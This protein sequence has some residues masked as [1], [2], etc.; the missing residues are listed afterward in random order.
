MQVPTIHLNGTSRESLL[1]EYEA[2]F[3]AVHAAY[4]KVQAL[5]VHGRDYYVQGTTAFPLAQAE[6]QHRLEQLSTIMHELKG[7][8]FALIKQQER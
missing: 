4:E 7:V 2:A 3:H 6:H 8:Y 5:T 1:Q